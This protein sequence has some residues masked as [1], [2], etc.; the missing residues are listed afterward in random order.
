MATHSNILAWRIPW[1]EEPGGHNPWG[2][3]ESDLTKWLIHFHQPCTRVSVSPHPCQ[4]LL[5]SF[6]KKIKLWPSSVAEWDTMGWLSVSVV[7]SPSVSFQLIYFLLKDNYFTEFWCFLW[8]LNMNQPQVYIHPLPFEPPSHLPFFRA[9]WVHCCMLS[10]VGLFSSPWTIVHKAPL[11][12]GPPR[13]EYW[14]ELSFPPPRGSSQPRDWT[15]VFYSPCIGRRVL[16]PWDTWEVQ[17]L[18][19]TL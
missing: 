12:M 9:A 11:S 10:H 19:S 5:F 7:W 1:T 6:L 4:Y 13:Q 3:K 8:N 17:G 15:H 16:H 2:H 14:S 18:P